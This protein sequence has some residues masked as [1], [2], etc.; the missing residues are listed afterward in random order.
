MALSCTL[1]GAAFVQSGLAL[2]HAIGQ[3]VSAI[4][5]APHGA[6]LAVCLPVIIK[7]TIPEAESDFA[8]VAEILDASVRDLPN[9]EKAAMLPEI[10]DEL[11]KDID[12]KRNVRIIR[13]D[14]RAYKRSGRSLPWRIPVGHRRSPEES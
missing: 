4:T 7:W 13:H 5:D 2:P 14:E 3:P 1:A 9:S 10:L 8:D 11:Y 12:I 6:T